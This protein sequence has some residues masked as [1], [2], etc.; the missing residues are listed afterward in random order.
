MTVIVAAA[1]AI[2]KF[3]VIVPV[4]RLV[5]TIVATAVSSPALTLFA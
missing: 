4:Q 5:P 2:E 3:V 1:F